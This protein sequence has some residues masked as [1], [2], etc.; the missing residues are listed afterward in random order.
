MVQLSLLYSLENTKNLLS[1]ETPLKDILDVDDILDA[2][3]YDDTTGVMTVEC[4]DLKALIG[5]GIIDKQDVIRLFSEAK[6]DFFE[7]F[8]VGLT[9]VEFS[10]KND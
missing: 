7:E 2:F 3:E 4:D 8:E 1:V 10:S 6:N 9:D 5:S